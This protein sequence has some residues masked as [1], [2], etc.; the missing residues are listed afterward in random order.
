VTPRNVRG[1]FRSL[2]ING[3][4]I[5]IPT[6]VTDQCKSRVREKELAKR[7]TVA[8]EIAAITGK[9]VARVARPIDGIVR[10]WNGVKNHV[11]D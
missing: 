4:S 3:G 11:A 10:R 9:P 2:W 5:L 7:D 6:T 8:A 1:H